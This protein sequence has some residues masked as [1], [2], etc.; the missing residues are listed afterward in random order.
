MERETRTFAE[1][2]H[3]VV[4]RTGMSELRA[5]T[6]CLLPGRQILKLTETTKPAIQYFDPTN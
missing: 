3:R 6:S 4:A 1:S 2:T 5:E